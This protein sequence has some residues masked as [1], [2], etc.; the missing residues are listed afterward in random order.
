[1]INISNKITEKMDLDIA[2]RVLGCGISDITE[3]Y[4]SPLV[5][6]TCTIN[7]YEFYLFRKI[8]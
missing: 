8:Y 3:D 5:G 6:K 4:D 2:Q 1:M 7:F